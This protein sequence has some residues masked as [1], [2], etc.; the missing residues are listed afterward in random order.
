MVFASE[1]DDDWRS[2][3]VRTLLSIYTI[4]DVVIPPLLAETFQVKSKSTTEE[5]VDDKSDE[6]IAT[7]VSDLMNK[8]TLLASFRGAASPELIYSRGIR[9]VRMTMDRCCSLIMQQFDGIDWLFF[10]RLFS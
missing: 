8:K 3:N 5:S 1:S 7:K 9:Y 6:Y 4:Q 2:S 10:R